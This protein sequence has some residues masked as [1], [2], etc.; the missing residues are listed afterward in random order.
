MEV[1]VSNIYEISGNTDFAYFW[2]EG[3]KI[4]TVLLKKFQIMLFWDKFKFGLYQNS[5]HNSKIEI[6]LE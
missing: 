2:F 3:L 1:F 5:Y 4:D 6:A